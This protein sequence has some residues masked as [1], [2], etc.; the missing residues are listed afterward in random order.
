MRG[1]ADGLKV[2]EEDGR[3]KIQITDL[4][5]TSF[6][7][8]FARKAYYEN[9]HLQAAVYTWLAHAVYEVPTT[10]IEYRFCV[11]ENKFPYRVKYAKMSS[12]AMEAGEILLSR[13][14]EAVKGWGDQ[15]PNFLITEVEE[16]G[17][18]SL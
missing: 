18:W 13:C 6:F 2:Y 5:T 3:K 10:D 15:E 8:D 4:K 12:E 7:K 17:D 9:Y 1:K 14:M 11:V 16:I